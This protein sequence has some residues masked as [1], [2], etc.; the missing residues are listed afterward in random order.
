M[1]PPRGSRGSRRLRATYAKTLGP[2]FLFSIPY[3]WGVGKDV[4]V[5]KS[6]YKAIGGTVLLVLLAIS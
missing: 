5:I 6:G 3:L 2:T 1:D 4:K